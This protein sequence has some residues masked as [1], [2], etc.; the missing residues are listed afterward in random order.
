MYEKFL[1]S[2]ANRIS[3]YR[4]GEMPTPT[5]AHVERWVRQFR[6]P[7]RSLI[8]EELDHIL[9]HTYL[10][11]EK[12]RRFLKT[13]AEEVKLAGDSP[14]NFWERVNL[15]QIQT[16]GTSQKDMV[17]RLEE[18]VQERY[19]VRLG[20]RS[21]PTDPFIYLDDVLFTGN[22]AIGDLKRWI[23]AQPNQPSTL[24]MVF[25]VVYAG[26]E[27]YVQQKLNKLIQDSGKPITFQIWRLRILEDR[28]FQIN[29]SEVF[30]PSRAN[31]DADVDAFAAKLD[32]AGYPPVLRPTGAMPPTPLFHSLQG[33]DTLEWELLCTGS[34][35]LNRCA[36]P[37][38]AMRPLGFSVL[39]TLGFGATVVTYR[40]CPNNAPL[41]LW[42]GNPDEPEGRPLG[43]YPLFPRRTPSPATRALSVEQAWGAAPQRIANV[44][45]NANDGEDDDLEA[46]DLYWESEAKEALKGAI[47]ALEFDE[48]E[49]L[50]HGY[51]SPPIQSEN[52]LRSYLEDI[53]LG[54]WYA[55]VPFDTGEAVFKADAYDSVSEAISGLEERIRRLSW[56]Q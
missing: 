31:G 44:I 9:E 21:S 50:I 35:I 48:E 18:V 4:S 27:Y 37:S 39:K 43:W 46:Y 34:K 49:G 54:A 26:G 16:R 38:I 32:A 40:N 2:I 23:E 42:W 20:E 56:D 1:E 17:T 25:M 24:H 41:A 45:E 3:D 55:Y 51:D 52:Q 30:R 33:R 12:I 8:L 11:K 14:E 29:E 15:L 28:K 36:N 19:G 5:P 6:E 10:S 53:Y 13:L 22:T 47:D 7:S